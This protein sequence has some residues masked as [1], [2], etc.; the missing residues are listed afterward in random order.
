MTG[1]GVRRCRSVDA[2]TLMRNS[3][4]SCLPH[5]GTCERD[6]VMSGNAALNLTEDWLEPRQA[7]GIENNPSPHFAAVGTSPV[8]TLQHQLQQAAL[9]GFF[10]KKP[11]RWHN[12]RRVS[13]AIGSAAIAL[14]VGVAGFLIFVG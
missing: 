6:L 13:V 7:N 9:R 12:P 5:T 11:S 14:M 2:L 10:D 8:A 3:F 1:P 4:I